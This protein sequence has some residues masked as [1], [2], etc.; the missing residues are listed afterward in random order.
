MVDYSLF[1]AIVQSLALPYGSRTYGR[2]ILGHQYSCRMVV[3]Y[4]QCAGEPPFPVYIQYYYYLK[5]LV[6]TVDFWIM[7]KN[8]QIHA[9][10][11]TFHIVFSVRI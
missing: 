6:G 11:A 2:N 8:L 1:G 3:V 7:Y 5:V 10:R 9:M 4:S